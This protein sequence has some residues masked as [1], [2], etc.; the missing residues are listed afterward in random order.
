MKHTITDKIDRTTLIPPEYMAEIVPAPKACKIE[1]TSSCNYKCSFCSNAD[2][3]DKGTM[4]RA[5]FESTLLELRAVGVEEIGLFFLGEP[6][7]CSW[8]EEA[9][10]FAKHVAKF[11]YVFLTTNGSMATPARVKKCME[12]GLNSLKFSLNYASEAQFKEIARVKGKLYHKAIENIKAARAIRDEGSYDCDLYASSIEFSG[13]QG[14]AMRAV[15][16]EMTPYLD[17]AYTLPLF[18]FSDDKVVGQE[19][20]LGFKPVAGNPGRA[21]NMRPPLPCWSGFRELHIERDGSINFCCFSGEA[22]RLGNVSEGIMSVWNNEAARALRRAHLA[23]DVAG[24]PCAKC[25]LG[26]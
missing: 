14:E 24:T 5:L 21:G 12:N 11:P 9:I 16:E 25:A 6:F 3:T 19:Q 1:I 18:S 15:V 17:E 8:L 10:Y 20:E 4:D 23:K 7:T 22:F 13:E 26:G 2:M